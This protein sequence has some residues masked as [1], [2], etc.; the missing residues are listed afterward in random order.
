MAAKKKAAPAKKKS[1]ASK[2]G[3]TEAEHRA[4]MKGKGAKPMKM[5]K[6]GGY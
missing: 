2:M 5:P 1:A 4:H 3:M 6:R